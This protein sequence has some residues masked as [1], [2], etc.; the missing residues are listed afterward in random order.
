MP[1]Y[2]P[3]F[4]SALM[5]CA[6]QIGAVA[7]ATTEIEIPKDDPATMLRSATDR[8]LQIVEDTKQQEARDSQAYYQKIDDVLSQIVD[9]EYFARSVMA[10]H[11]SVARYRTLSSDEERRAFRERITRFSVV[12][13]D[14]LMAS[15]ADALL[16]FDGERITWEPAPPSRDPND[17]TLTQVV[18]AKSGNNYK[19][20]YRMRNTDKSGWLV[21]NVIVEGLN[22]GQVYRTQ[23]A[24]AVQ[25]NKGNVDYV[26]ENWPKLMSKVTPETK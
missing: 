10:T 3:F 19:V 20:Q 13:K 2:K 7:A 25:N 9:M 4:L 15:Y 12:L 11:A 1:S 5:L 21:Q 8:V 26:V 14:S 18:H 24:D 23:F 22:L 17:I 16:A 6:L